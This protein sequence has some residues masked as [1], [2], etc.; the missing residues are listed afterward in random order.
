VLRRGRQF[1]IAGDS[2]GLLRWLRGSS[3]GGPGKVIAAEAGD[4]EGWLVDGGWGARAQ[5]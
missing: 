4:G 2:D 1:L 3:A 5:R